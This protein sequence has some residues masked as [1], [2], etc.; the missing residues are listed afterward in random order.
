MPAMPLGSWFASM[1][2]AKDEEASVLPIQMTVVSIRRCYLH[3]GGFI[4]HFV[5]IYENVKNN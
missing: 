3:N 5:R 2:A 4:V 1:S